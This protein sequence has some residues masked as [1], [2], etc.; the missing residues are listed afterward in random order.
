M[1][2]N[3]YSSIGSRYPLGTVVMRTT[4]YNYVK[5]RE[6]LIPEHRLKMQLK[7]GHEL[8][9]ASDDQGWA[10]K[11]FHLDNTLRGTDAFND[12]KNLTV[13]KVRTTKWTAMRSH[14]VYMPKKEP[15]KLA[16][17]VRR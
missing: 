10:H 13:V 3:S 8:V 12:E 11:V 1:S 15:V 5:T 16:D 4:G 14:I 17:F 7:L 6:G 2:K 9:K